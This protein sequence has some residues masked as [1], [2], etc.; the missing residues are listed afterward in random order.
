MSLTLRRVQRDKFLS[1]INQLRPPSPEGTHTYVPSDPERLEHATKVHKAAK[2]RAKK[3][4]SG[5]SEERA[6]AATKTY[7]RLYTPRK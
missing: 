4:R 5:S 2:R 6:T 1:L 3:E 7:K